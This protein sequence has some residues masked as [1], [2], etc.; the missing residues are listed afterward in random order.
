[1]AELVD[2]LRLFGSLS[3]GF[4]SA[5]IIVCNGAGVISAS[6]AGR[7]TSVVPWLGGVLGVGACL[8]CPYQIVWWF[9]WVP[10]ILDFSISL[11]VAAVLFH[12]IARLMGWSSPFDSTS[13]SP[14]IDEK[15]D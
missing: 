15:R 3:L 9:A 4:L 12:P 13:E 2:T 8:M 5:L 7:S 6:R 10:L 1:M 11:L 14:P